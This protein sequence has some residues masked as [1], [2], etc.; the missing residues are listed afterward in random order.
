[1]C[2][3]R[4]MNVMG[5]TGKKMNSGNQNV[6]KRSGVLSR[7]YFHMSKTLILVW[8]AAVVVG[9]QNPEAYRREADQVALDIIHQ[10]QY[11]ALK[12]IKP[13]SIERPS[14]T[15]RR[16]LLIDQNLPHADVEALGTDA[17]RPVDHW[18]EE[19]YPKHTVS[20]NVDIFPS[21]GKP[22]VIS[23]PQALQVAARNNTD[24]QTQKEFI[25]RNALDLD[26]EHAAFRNTFLVAW[27]LCWAPIKVA[28]ERLAVPGPAVQPAGTKSYPVVLN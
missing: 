6:K 7:P 5:S 2:A 21:Q 20:P 16:R 12:Q 22:L 13:F 27:N 23:L 8:L 10:K 19:D 17:L 9:C 26:L 1:M 18:P 11:I 28:P 14:N 4:I 24:Y 3:I 15:L 25:F